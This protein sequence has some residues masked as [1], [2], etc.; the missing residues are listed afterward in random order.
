MFCVRGSVVICIDNARLGRKEI[1]DEKRGC[2]RMLLVDPSSGSR[3][4]FL[5]VIPLRHRRERAKNSHLLQVMFEIHQRLRGRKK[6][7]ETRWC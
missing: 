3:L 7:K 5:H 6:G 1:L 2:Q 4:S